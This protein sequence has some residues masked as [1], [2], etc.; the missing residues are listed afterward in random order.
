[1]EMFFIKPINL[2]S[3]NLKSLKIEVSGVGNDFIKKYIIFSPFIS[4]FN[5]ILRCLIKII[6]SS[7]S[8]T[9]DTC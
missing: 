8:C 4:W 2:E 3:G 7:I 6:G 9:H 1:M 5:L